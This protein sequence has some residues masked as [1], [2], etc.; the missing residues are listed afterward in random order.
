MRLN[1]L[2]LS[3]VVLVAGAVGAHAG[4]RGA[5]V[6]HGRVPPTV[7]MK[8]SFGSAAPTASLAAWA[9]PNFTPGRFGFS[10]PLAVLVGSSNAG[11]YQVTLVS[12]RARVNA[13]VKM[14]QSAG[15]K[16]HHC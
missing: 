1:A 8:V 7:A 15:A 2:P 14:H 16:V 4:E 12:E 11:P 9:A 6:L 10:E 13:G 5:L 3:M